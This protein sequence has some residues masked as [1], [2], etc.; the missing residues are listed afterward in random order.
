MSKRPSINRADAFSAIL[1]GARIADAR[2]ATQN[3][4]LDDIVVRLDQPRKR[5]E[6][7]GLS[8]LAESIRERGVLQPVVL[9][10][11]N[12]SYELL[13][14]E[15][16]YRAAQLVGLEAIPAVVVAATDGEVREIALIENLNREDLNPLEET[17]AILNLLSSKLSIPVERV[18]Q[19]LRSMYDEER[20][21]A[22]NTGVSSETKAATQ[23]VFAI[24]GRLTISSFVVH[25]LPLLRL[26]LPLLEALRAGGLDYTKAK[27]LASVKDEHKRLSLLERVQKE[28]LSREQLKKEIEALKSHSI[29]SNR[30]EVAVD[31]N[32]LKRKLTPNRIGRLPSK[33]QAKLKKLLREIDTLLSE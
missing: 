30:T 24:V 9:R 31:I 20:G 27:L 14:G 2:V 16:R 8:Q 26:P 23:Q 32:V 33:H 21:R 1:D 5:F 18:I 11:R 17:D 7:K 6:E 29:K 3:V 15:R 10:C 12:D 4:P 25:R 22:G 13:A 28:S 19:V